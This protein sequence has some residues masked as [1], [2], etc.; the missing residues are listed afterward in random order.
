MRGGAN[1]GDVSTQGRGLFTAR[2]R[3]RLLRVLLAFQN[4]CHLPSTGYIGPLGEGS[5]A[6]STRVIRRQAVDMHNDNGHATEW[7]R[8]KP[9]LQPQEFGLLRAMPLQLPH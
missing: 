2:L 6:A 3:L 4:S 7:P 8:G 5:P 9:Y 1:K